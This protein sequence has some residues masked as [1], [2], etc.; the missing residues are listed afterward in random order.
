M[1]FQGYA[2]ENLTDGIKM[3]LR[4]LEGRKDTY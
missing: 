3:E 4:N 2:L 1:I